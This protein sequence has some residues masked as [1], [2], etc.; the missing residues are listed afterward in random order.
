MIKFN[1][2]RQR[3]SSDKPVTVKQWLDKR[4]AGEFVTR[5]EFVN[6]NTIM[7]DT[8]RDR[9]LWR[10]KVLRWCQRQ[11]KQFR[12]EARELGQIAA[13]TVDESES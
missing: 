4:H 3:Q 5:N 8:F 13:G 12:G 9:Y 2:R 10:Y 7:L 1:R 11:W 6:I